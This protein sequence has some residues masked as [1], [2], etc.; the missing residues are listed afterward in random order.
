MGPQD[1]A[2]LLSAIALPTTVLVAVLL[3]RTPLRN[4]LEQLANSAK[5]SMVKIRFWGVE[6]ELPVEQATA[7]LN[8]IQEE[9]I[10][11]L[12]RLSA[13]EVALFEKIA[14]NKGLTVDELSE[15]VFKRNES[16]EH[17][18]L[19]HLR[20]WRLIE[21]DRAGRKPGGIGKVIIVRTSPSLAFW[22][23]H[24]IAKA[25][26]KK[27]RGQFP[28]I[29]LPRTPVNKGIKKGRSRSSNPSQSMCHPGRSASVR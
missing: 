22:Y 28:R 14:D 27:T 23:Y 10:D 8:E 20:E 2:A 3:F 21:Q 19:R 18:Q 1:L 15:G 29:P 4:L 16:P 17:D 26:T 13:P 6:L 11:T 25:E 5:L 12:K 9:I 24:Y 7:V